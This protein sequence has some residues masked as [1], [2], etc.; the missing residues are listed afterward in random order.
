LLHQGLLEPLPGSDHQVTPGAY[1][2]KDLHQNCMG[3]CV[4]IV[5]LQFQ[6]ANFDA[7]LIL[8]VSG[9]LPSVSDALLLEM[10]LVLLVIGLNLLVN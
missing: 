3:L 4:I 8:E 10:D 7:L 6:D 1:L 2:L 5:L 9:Q